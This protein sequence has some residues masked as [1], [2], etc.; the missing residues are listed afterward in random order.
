MEALE[1][2][3]ME[4][5]PAPPGKNKPHGNREEKLGK[6]PTLTGLLDLFP[7]KVS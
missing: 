7:S 1:I 5:N 2:L 6:L 4:K 3:V